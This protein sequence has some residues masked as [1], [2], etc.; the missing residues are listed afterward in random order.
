MDK[1]KSIV[2]VKSISAAAIVYLFLSLISPIVF[3][4]DKELKKI[5]IPDIIL[6]SVVLIFN[7]GILDRLENFGLSDKGLTAKFKIGKDEVPIE[8]LGE[9]ITSR[10]RELETGIE[11]VKSLQIEPDIKSIELQSNGRTEIPKALEKIIENT[12]YPMLESNLWLGRYVKTLAKASSVSEEMMLDFCKSRDDI[13]LFEDGEQ[14]VA[15]LESRLL[16]TTPN[17]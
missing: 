7:S 6:I 2:L 16:S 14:W 10:L 8:N 3:G 9:T 4:K 11:S 5:E 15:A 1:F 13:G 12:I 17:S